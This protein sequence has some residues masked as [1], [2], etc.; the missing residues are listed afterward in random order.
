MYIA[1]KPVK[2]G[3]SIA[4]AVMGG[5]FLVIGR[6]LGLPVGSTTAAPWQGPTKHRPTPERDG[7][8]GGSR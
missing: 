6:A 3:F 1:R 7:A 5:S 2:S 4:D 8:S